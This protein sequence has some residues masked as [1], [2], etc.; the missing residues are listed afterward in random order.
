MKIIKGLKQIY[1]L[2]AL[3]KS[4]QMVNSTTDESEMIKN[5]ENG[6][7]HIDSLK[8]IFSE[9]ASIKKTMTANDTMAEQ[10]FNTLH[11]FPFVQ[12]FVNND[13]D[14]AFYYAQ[15]LYNTSINNFEKTLALDWSL[16]ALGQLKTQYTQ[17]NDWLD[18][19]RRFYNIE[20]QLTSHVKKI[21]TEH[22]LYNNLV[23]SCTYLKF[24]SHEHTD[25]K[26]LIEEQLNSLG[27]D[28]FISQNIE[29]Q[30]KIWFTNSVE[31][32]TYQKFEHFI[33]QH[34]GYE[35]K[36]ESQLISQLNEDKLNLIESTEKNT[37]KRKM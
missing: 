23:M 33:A 6:I 27:K 19:N 10:L 34:I 20:E 24:I 29:M 26:N 14:Q 9:D 36:I 30:K 21:N 2:S 18:Y 12:H 35:K 31:E 1:Y 7:S 5:V 3:Q 16:Q 37:P 17:S 4:L 8:K 22:T 15:G 25:A 32:D 13:F 11:F 28:N